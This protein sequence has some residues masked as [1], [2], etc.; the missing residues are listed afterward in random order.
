MRAYLID[1]I[2]PDYMTKIEDFLKKN[3]SSSNLDQIYWIEIPDHLLSETQ[4]GHLKCQ[5]H[6]F[7]VEVGTDWV[8]LEFFVR[9]LTNLGCKCIGYCTRQQ[10]DY[11]INFANSMIEQLC[12]KT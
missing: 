8:K 7:A 5:P 9:T 1:E 11:V 4:S 3:A 12:I 10:R 2:L 6:V